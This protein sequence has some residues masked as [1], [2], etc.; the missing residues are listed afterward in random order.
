MARRERAKR[1][2]QGGS[3]NTL[4]DQ[5]EAQIICSDGLTNLLRYCVYK[6]NPRIF[7]N[8]RMFSSLDPE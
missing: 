6:E 2:A 3:L 7:K 4:L 1:L 5:V 8:R